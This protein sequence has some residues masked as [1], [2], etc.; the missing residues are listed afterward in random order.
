MPRTRREIPR[1][2]ERLPRAHRGIPRAQPPWE[3]AAQGRR[4]RR[5]ANGLE[6]SG[7]QPGKPK[8]NRLARSRTQAAP[9]TERASGSEVPVTRSSSFEAPVSLL[10][11][12]A[13][14][15]TKGAAARASARAAGLPSRILTTLVSLFESVP[16][17]P[18]NPSKSKRRSNRRSRRI[19]LI[20]KA[21]APEA[22]ACR[23]A[24][25]PDAGQRVPTLERKGPA[26]S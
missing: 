16:D 21:S 17:G 13:R 26:G 2:R 19:S 9:D 5:R 8:G 11:L 14:V 18:G 4:R 3:E 15:A 10:V 6:Q 12:G 24:D 25:G 23:P 1:T 20:H 22:R 7:R